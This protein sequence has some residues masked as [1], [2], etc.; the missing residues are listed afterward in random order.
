MSYSFKPMTEEEFSTYKLLEE[1]DY[2]FEVVKSTRKTSKS[3]NAMAELNIGVWDKEGKQY[4]IYDYL[5][6]SN[7]PLNIKKIKHFCDAVG[8]QDQYKQ[9]IIPDA[10]EGNSG[11]VSIGTKDKESNGNGGFYPAK[12]F[13]IDYISSNSKKEKT[14]NFIDDELPF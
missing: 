6:F 3:G 12:N 7:V 2:E 11:K 14:D 5:V 13:V 9:G 10:L 8:L 4:F 1:G